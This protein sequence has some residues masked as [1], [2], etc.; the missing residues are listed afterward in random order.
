MTI[1]AYLS[2]PFVK[3]NG[4]YFSQKSSVNFV[5]S[6][7]PE[8]KVVTVG[9]VVE[10]DLSNFSAKISQEEFLSCPNY[11]SII[12]FCLQVIKSPKFL[13]IY[14]SRCYEII[15]EFPEAK[16]WVRNPS[17]GCLIFSVCALNRKRILYNHMCA[18]A[19][20]AWNSDKYSGFK[21]VLAFLFSRV[22]KYLS[23][24]VAKSKHTVNLCTGD[25]LLRFCQNVSS[26]SHLLIDSNIKNIK[27]YRESVL[28]GYFTFLFI[29]RVQQDKGIRELIEAFCRIKSDKFRL[30]VVGDGPLLNELKAENINS[31]IEFIGQVPNSDLERYLSSSNVVVVPSK[32]NYEGFPRVILEAWSYSLPVIV[33]DVGGVKSFVINEKNGYLVKPGEVNQLAEAMMKIS[34]RRNYEYFQKNCHDLSEVTTEKYWVQRFKNDVM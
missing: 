31:R 11:E 12:D 28:G 6:C 19:M 13:L 30:K 7:F 21:K 34:V 23:I 18:N 9:R 32:N 8:E 33:S 24:Y 17:I 16:I 15:D 29:G 22:I 1:I 2:E 3:K 5:K 27:G 14:I 26:N 25:E 10:K 20:E 4:Y